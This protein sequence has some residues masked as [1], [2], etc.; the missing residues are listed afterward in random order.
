MP[1]PTPIRKL[2]TLRCTGGDVDEQCIA[3]ENKKA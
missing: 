3:D 1:T 2:K